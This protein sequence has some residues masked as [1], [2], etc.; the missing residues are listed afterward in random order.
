MRQFPAPVALV[1]VTV[2]DVPVPVPDFDWT[3]PIGYSEM[4]NCASRGVAVATL[5]VTNMTRYVDTPATHS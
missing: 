4:M 2:S 1:S 5:V 3:R